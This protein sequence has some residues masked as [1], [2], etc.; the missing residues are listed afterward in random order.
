MAYH[1]ARGA[2]RFHTKPECQKICPAAGHSVDPAEPTWL[3][4]GPGG[5]YI[6][7]PTRNIRRY[8][9]LRVIQWIRL[10]QYGLSSGQGD[11][12]FSPQTGISEDMPCCRSFGGSSGTN[13]AYHWA[14]GTIHFHLKPEYQKICPAT[15]H[16]VDPAEPTWLVIGPGG[17]GP[18]VVLFTFSVSP[19]AIVLCAGG[20]HAS[21]GR[22][23]AL[24]GR[25][26]MPAQIRRLQV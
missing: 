4:I 3:V 1:Q 19:S 17:P 6:F 20:M 2:V 11:N 13:M 5:Q 12:T 9:L 15:G 8:A 22:Q 7:T 10:N 23:A 26:A 18:S 21:A 25:H 24:P 16:S 14:R